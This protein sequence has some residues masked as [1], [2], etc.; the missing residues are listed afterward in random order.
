MQLVIPTS[1]ESGRLLLRGYQARDGPMLYAVAD[2]NRAHLQRYES[3]NIILGA[4]SLRE[5]GELVNRLVAEWVARSSFFLGAFEKKSGEF[6]AQVYIGPVNW[7]LPEFEIGYFVDINH[8]GQGYVTEAVKAT[9]GFTF[10]HL[11]AQR[12]SLRCSDS[13]T[14]SYRVAERCGLVREGHLR[15]NQRNPDG[16]LGGELI[17]GLLRSEFEAWNRQPSPKLPTDRGVP[18]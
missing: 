6:I 18:A 15:Q 3:G 10:T 8:Q 5:A 7:E 2:R 4:R 14:R 11:K 16:S 9:L 17:Y 13:N 12:V 1:F